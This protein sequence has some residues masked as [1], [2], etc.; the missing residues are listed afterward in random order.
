[1]GCP[2]PGQ[3]G[4]AVALDTGPEETRDALHYAQE[5]AHGGENQGGDQ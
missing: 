4:A 5:V 3:G 1:M 2:R